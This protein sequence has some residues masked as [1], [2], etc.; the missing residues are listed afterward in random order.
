MNFGDLL[1]LIGTQFGLKERGWSERY[2]N[3]QPTANTGVTQ[4]SK[5]AGLDDW[6]RV[7]FDESTG[8]PNYRPPVNNDT[9]VTPPGG[10]G[11]TFSGSTNT[12]DQGGSDD[13]AR[14]REVELAE[15]ARRNRINSYKAQAGNIRGEAE[16]NFN[17]ILK[18][19]G[20]FRDRSKEAFTNAG[21][22]ITNTASEILGSN[23]RTGRELMGEGRARGRALG[24]GDSS[25]FNVQNKIAGN[26]AATQGSTIAERGQ[27]ERANTL[28]FNERNDQAQNQENEANTYLKS[29][30]DRAAAVEN[31][32]YD[33][34]EEQFANSLN[35]IVKY[36]RNLAAIKPVDAASV[37]PYTSDFG[38]ITD[39]LN[40]VLSNMGVGGEAQADDFANP[41]NPTNVFELLKRRGIVQ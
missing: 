20:A 37:T 4:Q 9:T 33:A 38:G 34:G 32:G 14:R 5:D 11:S 17:N 13:D 16:G 15:L 25:K 12:G 21:Q 36:Q 41:V 30:R 2:N 18:A 29:A 10:G 8:N 35:D 22:E 26:L 19:I 39:T 31:M 23:A 28:Q 1:D 40:G 6:R 3:N 24:L 7:H 27:N